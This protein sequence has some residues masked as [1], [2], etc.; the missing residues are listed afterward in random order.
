MKI[1]RFTQE[2]FLARSVA[3]HGNRYDYSGSV[4]QG[5]SEK[6]EVKCLEHGPF[7][8]VASDHWGGHGCRKC[9]QK[10]AKTWTKEHDDFL[11]QNYIQQG[12]V[13]CAKRLGKTLSSVYSRLNILGLRKNAARQEPFMDIHNSVWARLLRGAKERGFVVEID[14]QM[15]WDLYVKQGRRCALTG[16]PVL[17]SLIL[18]ETTASVDRID[19]SLGYLPNNIQIVHKMANRSKVNYPDHEFYAMCKAVHE[20]RNGDF[21]ESVIEWEWDTMNDTEVP[22]RRRVLKGRAI[23]SVIQFDDPFYEPTP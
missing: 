13:S 14:R 18:S 15:I 3:V 1:P 4:Y 5:S 21:E 16:W 7:Q 11:I 22:M 8:I 6:V 9:Y 23:D 20:H 17:F 10:R 2:Q 12:A 19:S